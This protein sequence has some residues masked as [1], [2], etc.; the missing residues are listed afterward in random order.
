MNTP[1]YPYPQQPYLQPQ[2]QLQPPLPARSQTLKMWAIILLASGH[3]LGII[4]TFTLALGIGIC[5]L[6][7]AILAEVAGFICLCLI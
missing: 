5:I 3:A 4:G 1:R 6:P 2:P 7:L